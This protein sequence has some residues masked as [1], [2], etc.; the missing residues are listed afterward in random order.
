[1]A[2]SGG[3]FGKDHEFYKP[4]EDL[5][6][7][8]GA[9]DG[10]QCVGAHEYYYKQ[11]DS[12]SYRWQAVHRATGSDRALYGP[13]SPAFSS[14]APATAANYLRNRA[15][16]GAPGPVQTSQAGRAY[17]VVQ[18][19][20]FRTAFS[21]WSNN[22]HHLLADAELQNGIIDATGGFP[23]VEQMI[24][25][26][27]LEKQYNVNLWKNMMILPQEYDVGCRIQLPTHPAG[28]SHPSYSAKVKAGVD[29]ALTP[30]KAVVEAVK[31]G[32][33]THPNP[34]P[35]DIKAAL[36][37]LSMALHAGVVALRPLVIAACGTN[38]QISINSFAS[39][40]GTS[41]G[42]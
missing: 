6:L 32:D 33:K 9:F 3:R 39:Q 17:Q 41:I 37:A 31:K 22:A 20:P 35:V 42:V 14:P 10:G 15:L 4:Y 16:T 36:E 34:D 29:A 21:P 25:Q 26:G 12:C 23:V 2:Q 11:R 18:G 38:D 28:D 1:M 24:V 7:S 30:Y 27:L 5:H 8:V 13:V 40:V 19:Q